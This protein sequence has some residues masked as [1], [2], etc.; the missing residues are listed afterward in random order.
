M[1]I[2]FRFIGWHLMISDIIF[3]NL[4]AFHSQLHYRLMPFH[5]I[6]I[7]FLI[8]G[9]LQIFS[10]V[11]SFASICAHF[12]FLI[13]EFC[14]KYFWALANAFV[15]LLDLPFD[16]DVFMSF[17]SLYN[18]LS[19]I[20][21]YIILLPA[22]WAHVSYIAFWSFPTTRSKQHTIASYHPHYFITPYSWALSLYWLSVLLP[23]QSC[24]TGLFSLLSLRQVY[25]FHSVLRLALF[26]ELY[27]YV[28]F[29]RC[30][31]AHYM[32]F[33]YLTFS[34]PPHI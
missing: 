12:Y 20:L 8:F 34:A 32:I 6:G 5:L 13:F 2:H 19:L 23:P 26:S 17:L 22:K 18:M 33:S 24:F 29:W 21:I 9:S 3:F 10:R 16:T 1:S 14:I 31:G 15:L 27:G 4:F 28:Y 11:E 30:D 7:Y 25:C